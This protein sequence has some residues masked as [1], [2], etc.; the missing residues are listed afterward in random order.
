MTACSISDPLK[1]FAASAISVM[2]NFAG[3]RFAATQVDLKDLSSSSLVW[4]V[5]EEDFIKATL[6]HQLRRGSAEMSFAVATMKIG[7]RWSCI[8][9]SRVPNIRFDKPPSADDVDAEANAFLNLVHPQHHRSHRFRLGKCLSQLAFT[10]A[11]ELLVEVAG[12]ESQQGH[13]PV[14]RDNLRAQA[15]AAAGNAQHQYASRRFD[16]KLPSLSRETTAALT[17][18]RL[19][20]VQAADVIDR[21]I[22]GNRFETARRP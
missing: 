19:Q 2:S 14:T 5:D 11:D 3:S 7:C 18:P 15:L 1:S 21:E 8:Q 16:A 9:D 4:Q 10:L 17:Q 13:L 12:I 22:G 20:I 6:S